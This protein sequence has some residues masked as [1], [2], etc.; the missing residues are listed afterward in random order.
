[1]TCLC[2][3]LLRCF[4]AWK[5]YTQIFPPRCYHLFLWSLADRKGSQRVHCSHH[6]LFPSYL[7]GAIINGWRSWPRSMAALTR[8]TPRWVC[9]T[10]V[11]KAWHGLQLIQEDQNW[12]FKSYDT[13]AQHL[14]VLSVELLPCLSR[15]PTVPWVGPCQSKPLRPRQGHSVTPAGRYSVS[16]HRKDLLSRTLAF[17]LR[18][19]S[20]STGSGHRKP[21]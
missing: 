20:N 12:R 17:S 19:I 11:A 8:S 5:D 6:S 7:P 15:I 1:M 14:R 4:L 2:Y 18:L 10:S 9:V 13:Q 21:V 3:L 16:S